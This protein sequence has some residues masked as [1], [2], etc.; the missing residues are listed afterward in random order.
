[1]KLNR[2]L[3][4]TGLLLTALSCRNNAPDKA[5][6]T[7]L[8]KEGNV[9]HP[10]WAASG[11]VYELNAHHF[12]TSGTLKAVEDALPV[13]NELGTNI[14]CLTPVHP[15]SE[16]L[17]PGTN[18]NFYSVKDFAKIHPDLGTLDDFRNLVSK[19]HELGMKVLMDW[20]AYGASPVNSL[21]SEH[22]DWFLTPAV[23][24]VEKDVQAPDVLY[25]DYSVRA[26][27][28]YMI[29]TMRWWIKET[30]LD[31]F[32][33]AEAHTLPVDFLEELRPSLF[34]V[35]E[36][37][38]MADS[39]SPELLRKAFNAGYNKGFA[40]IMRDIAK[41]YSGAAEAEIHFT[42]AGK[43]YPQHSILLQYT[44]SFL[45]DSFT[46][47]GNEMD[48]DTFRMFAALTFTVPGMPSVSGGLENCLDRSLTANEI[49]SS[50]REECEMFKFYQKLAVLRKSNIALWS[51]EGSE[52]LERIATNHGDKIFAFRRVRD[53]N[54][55]I[56]IF[57]FSP[58]TLDCKLENIN[59]GALLTEYFSS[60]KLEDLNQ[61]VLQLNPWDFKIFVQE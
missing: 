15:V 27:R 61:T 42:L 45:P 52:S 9:I 4:I 19:A 50:E 47:D 49:D 53:Y 29:D 5:S 17:K 31:G 12:S 2:F 18:G 43:I 14:L 13:L 28:D 40:G 30:G 36:V 56:C 20:V 22:P 6:L 46:G 26:V 8:D 3:L 54:R 51:G 41:G 34:S 33:C 35:K 16:I 57:N 11:V 23:S 48:D 55:V 59:D 1:M 58:D 7:G 37:F 32:R 60:M 25:F 24:I 21:V 38:L 44:H 39:E 10:D